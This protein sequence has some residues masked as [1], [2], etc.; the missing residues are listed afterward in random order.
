MVVKKNKS[1][2]RVFDR[3]TTF[4]AS[5][6][7]RPMPTTDGASPFLREKMRTF[8]EDYCK[9]SSQVR[10][11]S[12]VT[13]Y[14]KDSLERAR[15][16]FKNGIYMTESDGNA[17]AAVKYGTLPVEEGIR[18]VF[19]H[20]DSPGLGLKTKPAVVPWDPDQQLLHLGIIADLK[21]VGSVHAGQWA[22]RDYTVKGFFYQDGV[23]KKL[24]FPGYLADVNVHT[25]TRDAAGHTINEAYPKDGL[26]LIVGYNNLSNFLKSIGIKSETDFQTAQLQLYPENPTRIFGQGFITGH[27]HDARIGT[28][29]TLKAFEK[30][31]SPYTTVLIGFDREET[32]SFGPGGA[33]SP[34]LD[35]IVDNILLKSKVVSSRKELTESLKREIY[36]SSFA[37]NGD[38][39]VSASPKDSEEGR[40]DPMSIAKMAFGPFLLTED[41]NY[42]ADQSRREHVARLMKILGESNIIFYPVGSA[43]TQENSQLETC[44]FDINKKGLPTFAFGVPV[45][46]THSVI[47]LA[48]E[49]DLYYS[50]LGHKAFLKA[51]WKP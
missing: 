13:D 6:L 7:T 21:E 12:D 34:F 29:S 10:T 35:D 49:G 4:P 17:F 43:M 26:D 23:K 20:N 2:L 24:E 19:S 9:F 3:W 48:H 8:A 42:T 14:C 47:E 15:F 16:D 11:A 18:V 28:Y 37:I 45:V 30:T 27:A 5:Q 41:G 32:G 44:S 38:V 1:G 50:F 22:G 51:D 46:G 25:D 36:R 31:K 40:I 39:D 33:N